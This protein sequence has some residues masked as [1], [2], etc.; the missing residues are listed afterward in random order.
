MLPRIIALLVLPLL[1]G[2]CATPMR[3]SLNTEQRAKLGELKARVIVV[4][5]EVVAA[6]QPSQVSVA[7][8]GGLIGAMIDSSITN[9]RVKESQKL[10]GPF[11]ASIEDVDF[12]KE[13]NET[14]TRELTRYPIKT[15]EVV[16]TPRMVAMAE[17]NQMRAQL[18]PG[19]ALL[20]IVPRYSLTMD[21]RSLDA[22]AFVTIWDKGEGNSPIQRGVLRYQS[23]LVGTGGKVSMDMWSADNAALF[24]STLRESVTELTNLILMDADVG[25]TPAKPD[26]MKTFTLNT[27]L[28]QAE[29][30]GRSLK[31]VADRVIVLGEDGKLYSLPK[32]QPAAM[33]QR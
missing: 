2:A 16:T 21:F 24:R 5:D 33:A 31:E 7:T 32:A 4:Q 30:K 26:E 11:Y 22:D 28:Q 13:F 15:R 19:H 3:V 9:E 29:I 17:L 12:R 18:P 14:I 1:L 25:A 10:M 23:K 27:G 6:V 20:L 8:G